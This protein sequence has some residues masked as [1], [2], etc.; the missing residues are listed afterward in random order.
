VRDLL[1]GFGREATGCY[2]ADVEMEDITCGEQIDEVAA[3]MRGFEV[4]TLRM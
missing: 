2:D 1:E 3:D 4:S